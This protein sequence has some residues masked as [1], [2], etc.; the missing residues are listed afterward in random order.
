[1][2]LFFIL[3]LQT[4]L[5][6][7]RD[8]CTCGL[9]PGFFACLFPAFSGVGLF[10]LDEAELFVRPRCHSWTAL[11]SCLSFAVPSS[12]RLPFTGASSTFYEPSKELMK[13]AAYYAGVDTSPFVFAYNDADVEEVACP[14]NS[15][16]L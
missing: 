15:H 11:F 3:S 1:V 12:F 9:N 14:S 13:M 5:L 16:V 4:H 8:P 7:R 2:V 10:C 6:L